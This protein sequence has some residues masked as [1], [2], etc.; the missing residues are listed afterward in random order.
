MKKPR[1][2]DERILTAIL[3]IVFVNM[4]IVAYLLMNQIK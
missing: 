3:Y 2:I 1:E 4:C